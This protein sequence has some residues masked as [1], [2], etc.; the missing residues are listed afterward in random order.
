MKTREEKNKYNREWRA[1]NK[2]R[3]AE[4]RRTYKKRNWDTVSERLRL[5]KVAARL[6]DKVMA[7]DHYSQGK[8]ECA[9]CK[10]KGVPFLTIDHVKGGG[11]QHRKEVRLY[12]LPTWLRIRSYP[13]GYQIL[14]FNCNLAKGS[15][16][17]CPHVS[18]GK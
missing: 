17:E 10:E 16:P 3:T 5:N 9:C 14:C 2:E 18:S 8:N 12:Y 4:Q 15:K 1:N 11:H 6:K 13:T 7:I